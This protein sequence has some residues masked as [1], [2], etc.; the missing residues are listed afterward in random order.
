MEIPM[1]SMMSL[2]AK[3]QFWQAVI[4]HMVRFS[5]DHKFFF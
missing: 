1:I 5:F 2:S 3:D 4:P